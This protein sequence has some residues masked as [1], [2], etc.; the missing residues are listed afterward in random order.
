[1]IREDSPR[2]WVNLGAFGRRY[3]QEKGLTLPR[4]DDK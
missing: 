2:R 3:M 1:M 4:T